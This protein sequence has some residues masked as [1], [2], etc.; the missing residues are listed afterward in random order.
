MPI[1]YTS[2]GSRIKKA[3][4]LRGLTQE[5]LAERTNL[6]T[7]HISNIEN[8]NAV[9]SL[10]AVV[11]IANALSTTIDPLL[12]D[13][14]DQSKS[15]YETEATSLYKDCTIDEARILTDT[16]KNTLAV[17]RRHYRPHE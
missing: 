12:C 13:S 3:R 8:G 2:L 14:I 6:S 1:N 4:K 17:L 10:Q 7:T 5:Q 15:V 9:P 11:D 16:I